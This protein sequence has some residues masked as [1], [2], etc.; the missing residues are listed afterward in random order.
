LA[1]NG[2]VWWCH[3]IEHQ[4]SFTDFQYRPNRVNIDGV[5]TFWSYGPVG[6]KKPPTGDG[7]KCNDILKTQKI[8]N[9]CSIS[10]IM[11]RDQYMSNKS[12]SFFA[13]MSF[14]KGNTKNIL[15]FK[16]INF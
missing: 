5:M 11:Q 12:S 14:D 1:R 6:C 8:K 10:W 15:S 4:E 13:R 7:F 2:I 9:Q 3:L 16:K